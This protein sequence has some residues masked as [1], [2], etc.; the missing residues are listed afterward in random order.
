MS[1]I[2]FTSDTHL[3][4]DKDFIWQARGFSCVEEMNEAIVN[5]W[6]KIVK[7]EDTV[8]LLGD[9]IL[10]DIEKGYQYLNALNGY[11]NI[12]LGNHDGKTKIDLFKHIPNVNIMGYAWLLQYHKFNFFLSH[13]PS[14]TSNY[15]DKDLKKRTINLHGHV[16]SRTPW[17]NLRNPFMYDVGM[18]AHKCTPVHIDEII[19]DI[20][21][22]WVEISHLPTPIIPED[23]YPYDKIFT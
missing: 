6:N 22:R 11:I 15:D 5:N 10:N 12:I 7:P 16:H 21:Q 19:F 14:I 9:V 2:F 20:R 1:E 17:I 3:G 13:Y 18:D 23:N 4:H 8:Y